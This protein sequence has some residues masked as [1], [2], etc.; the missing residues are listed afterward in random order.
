MS[1]E[2]DRKVLLLILD[3]AGYHPDSPGNAVTAQHLPR[4]FERMGSDGFAVLEAAQEAV[5]LEAGQ[6]GNSEAG[7]LTI[8][9]G[10]VVSSM[11]R[12]ICESFEDGSKTVDESVLNLDIN[13]DGDQKDQFALGSIELVNGGQTV[14]LSGN[15]RVLLGLPSSLREPQRGCPSGGRPF[16]CC[17]CY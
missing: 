12:H 11:C 17:R 16:G 1:S 2:T 14:R 5:G 7:H 6:V 13:R 9:A 3:G 10:H 4:L 8:G 15:A